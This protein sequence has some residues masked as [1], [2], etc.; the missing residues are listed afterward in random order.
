ML[1]ST[2]VMTTAKPSE[3][4]ILL[5]RAEDQWTLHCWMLVPLS[6][7]L[8]S[9]AD[10]KTS[11]TNLRIILTRCQ[12]WTSMVIA[13][14]WTEALAAQTGTTKSQTKQ[15]LRASESQVLCL[16]NPRE[17]LLISMHSEQISMTMTFCEKGLN[18]EKLTNLKERTRTVEQIFG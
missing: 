16:P 15:R 1:S 5:I 13:K 6:A 17:N 8:T 18:E 9:E 3:T 12:I 2:T 7:S 10:P 4:T 11:L 14:S